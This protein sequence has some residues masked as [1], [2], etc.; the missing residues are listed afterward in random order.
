VSIHPSSV[1]SGQARLGND[2]TIGPFCVIEG[3]AVIGDG[4]TLESHVIVKAGTTLGRRNHVFE[5]C[6]LGGMPQHVRPPAEPGR[7]VIGDGNTLREHVTIHRS[8]YC[9]HV[10]SVGDNNL[11]MVNVHVAHDCRVG[12]HGI[13]ANNAMLAGHVSVEDRAYVSGAV[14]V[15]QFCR[16]GGLAMIGGAARVIKDVPPYVT[17][18]GGS[19]AVVGL[20]LVGLRRN[21]FAPSQVAELKAAYRLIYRSGLAWNDLLERLRAEFPTGPAARFHAFFL[22]GGARGFVQERREPP[23]TTLRLST[24]NGQ[25]GEL[26][27][28][29]G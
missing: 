28:K 13:F 24:A 20:N 18:D 10:T 5:G 12:S 27:A 26:R 1:V 4:C 23:G 14:G 21:G 29:A 17:L 8:L 6:V 11:L 7:L 2:V 9:D 15:H 3:D 25:D 19:G 22:S 16:I